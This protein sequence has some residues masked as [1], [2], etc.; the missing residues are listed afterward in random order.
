MKRVLPMLFLCGCSLADPRGMAA[1]SQLDLAHDDPGGVAVAIAVPPDLALLPDGVHLVVTLATGGQPP[2][3]EDFSLAQSAME[4]PAPGARVFVLRDADLPRLRSLQTSGAA[5]AVAGGHSDVT[6][7]VDAMAC[8]AVPHPDP[9][10]RGSVWM[11]TRAGAGFA[12]LFTDLPLAEIPGWEDAASK[13]A[14]C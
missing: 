6:M 8:L 10:M 2:R 7:A 5:S 11:R 12:P 14:P 3:S 4:G 1:M 13:L 9:D